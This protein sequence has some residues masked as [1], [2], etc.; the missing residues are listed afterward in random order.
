MIGR[1]IPGAG[2]SKSAKAEESESEEIED[3]FEGLKIWASNTRSAKRARRARRGRR[4]ASKV[5]FWKVNAPSIILPVAIKPETFT[6]PGKNGA[7]PVNI[8][9]L[10]CSV[11]YKPKIRRGGNSWY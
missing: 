6:I 4:Y 7:D 9:F 5:K 1:K 2:D 10:D 11:P 8:S 3:I